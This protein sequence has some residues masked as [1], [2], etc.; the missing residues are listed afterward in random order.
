LFADRLGRVTDHLAGIRGLVSLGRQGLFAHDN[1]HHTME[2]AYRAS[3]CLG[4]GLNWD[5]ERWQRYREQFR[6]HVVED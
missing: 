2:M 5:G 3:D 1:T 6:S 4:P